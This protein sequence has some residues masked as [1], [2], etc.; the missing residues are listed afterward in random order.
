MIEFVYIVNN[1]FYTN[2]WTNIPFYPTA[3]QKREMI[4]KFG[5]DKTEHIIQQSLQNNQHNQNN[6][7]KYKPPAT[8]S[9]N[10]GLGGV[11]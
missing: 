4:R 2:Q 7:K 3:E 11:K 1:N 6:Q 8:C 5:K 9:V 10:I